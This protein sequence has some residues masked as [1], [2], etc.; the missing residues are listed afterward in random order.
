MKH[1]TGLVAAVA[2]LGFLGCRPAAESPKKIAITTSSEEARTAFLKA[3]DMADNLRAVEARP[4][5][6]EAISKDPNFALAHLM[7]A[8]SSTTPK[9]FFDHM[10]A[11]SAAAGK[12]SEGE[13][14]WIQGAEAGAQGNT[15]ARGEA[16]SKLVAAFPNDERAHQLLGTHYLAI[17]D[18]DAAVAEFQKAVQLVPTFVPAYNLM[19]YAYQGSEK[20]KEAEGAF[21]K[22]IELIPNEPNPYDSLAE[23]LMKTGRFDESIEN[24]KKALSLDPQFASAYRGI[25]AGLIYQDNHKDAMTQL[26][27]EFDK[28]RDD[29]ERQQALLGMAVC[30]ADEGKL[31]EAQGKLSEASALAEKQGDK[32]FMARTEYTQGD[33]LLIAGRNDEAKAAF[34]KSQELAQQANVPDT[35]KKNAEAAYHGGLALVASAKKDFATAKKEAEIMRKGFEGL[36]NP[37]QM[38]TAHEVLGIVA[39]NQKNYDEAISELN[40]ANLRSPYVMFRLAQA[41]VGKKDPEKAKSYYQKAA[42]AYTLPDLQYALVRRQAKK[43]AG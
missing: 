33:V 34:T 3:R 5:L 42:T 25:S 41:Y 17:Q 15:K 39:L 35:V 14:L 36:G 21:R 16:Y 18:N 7:R 12:A 13:Q 1:A 20:Y 40:Q 23:L 28:A 22:Y 24:Y 30:Y 26:Q 19:G 37:N 4:L 10:K 27:Q 8:Q 6:D 32:A 11:A 29:G 43:A 9:E 2:L 31:K 38:R